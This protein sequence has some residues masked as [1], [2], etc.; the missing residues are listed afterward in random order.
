MAGGKMGAGGVQLVGP[1]DVLGAFLQKA[2]VHE[3]WISAM[4]RAI[5]KEAHHLAN[6]IR[7]S[8]N[9]Q[10]S[11]GK[12]WEPPS[13]NTLLLRR[14]K[15]TRG[16]T[17][18]LMVHGDLRGSIKAKRAGKTEWFV[19]VHRS[20]RARRTGKSLANIAAIQEFGA[21]NFDIP[22]TE[23]M[24]RFFWYLHNKTRGAWRPGS[25]RRAPKFMIMPIS[26]H[27][28]VITLRIPARPFIG[29]IWKAEKEASGY[30][31]VNQTMVEIGWPGSIGAAT[32]LGFIRGITG[33]RMR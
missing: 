7:N 9:N 13:A 12:K 32:G 23:K 24:R 19:G 21:D 25:R 28:T 17:K 18:A 20:A 6:E 30:R 2:S 5:G 22:V 26:K 31:I 3:R 15:G 11:A 4:D 27:K 29:P 16:R 1:W 8:F 10:G 33:S 14:A